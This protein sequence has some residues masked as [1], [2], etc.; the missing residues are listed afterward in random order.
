MIHVGRD[1]NG[2]E[3]SIPEFHTAVFGQSGVGKT[4][5]LKYM[6]SQVVKEGYR[7]FIFDSK[8]TG[9]EFEGI[10]TEVP[11]YLEAP[12]DPDMGS[13]DP[14]AFRSLVEGMRTKGKGNME[15]YRFA[16]IE[17][18]KEAETFQDIGEKL[19]AKL[20]DP[21]IR[22]YT[23]SMYSEIHFDYTRL[24]K[25][26]ERHSFSKKV[27]GLGDPIVRM[28]TWKLPNLALQGVVV[29][30]VVEELLRSQEKMVFLV[31]EA[32]NFVPQRGYSPAKSALQ[33]VDEQGRKGKIWGWYSGQTLTGFDK[34][35]MKN[36]WYW[37]M[38]REM[39]RNE[40]KDVY[41][42]QTTKVATMER[43][44][45]MGVREFLVS[46]PDFTKLVTVPLVDEKK[47]FPEVTI[48]IVPAPGWRE[49]E[50]SRKNP[51]TATFV[52]EV[53]R[54]EEDWTEVE[55]MIKKVEGKLQ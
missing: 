21:K 47:L 45:K 8:V 10:G 22:G 38:G 23:K 52:R 16:F 39:E 34:Q 26:L 29:R 2:E 33:D 28:P 49:L 51:G 3:V 32:P 36:V 42:T 15:R 17:I 54:G 9:P 40:A 24:M 5:L 50:G 6:I 27:Q 11:F 43:I 55:V 4:K 7:V 14:D 46:T 44:K 13:I 41:D 1:G 12:L 31:D 53:A 37:I 19:R 18:C 48:R 30:S 25:L 35:N 20:D